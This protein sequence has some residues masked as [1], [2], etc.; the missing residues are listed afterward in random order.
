LVVSKIAW[1][2][3]TGLLFVAISKRKPVDLKSSAARYSPF[4][5]ELSS[6]RIFVGAGVEIPETNCDGQSV[7]IPEFVCTMIRGNGTKAGGAA[8]AL[9][10]ANKSTTTTHSRKT[11]T[12]L[13]MQ[14]AK[15]RTLEERLKKD[16]PANVQ[17]RERFETP[18]YPSPWDVKSAGM[19]CV[20]W[21]SGCS[22]NKVTAMRVVQ[23]RI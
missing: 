12:N 10:P 5:R 17:T 14:L 4:S 20:K 3:G 1:G 19:C 6:T 2:I 13:V 9:T 15:E 8:T 11:W 23:G 7:N 21:C 22:R 18:K 16:K